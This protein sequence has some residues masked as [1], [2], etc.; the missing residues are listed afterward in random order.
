MFLDKLFGG[1]LERIDKDKDSTC[2]VD[3]YIFGL[4][5]HK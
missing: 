4:A 5:K 3:V 2:W 1:V